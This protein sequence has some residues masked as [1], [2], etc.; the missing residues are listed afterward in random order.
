MEVALQI[1]RAS[2]GVLLPAGD[3]QAADL[4]GSPKS[5]TYLLEV[6][7][8]LVLPVGKKIRFLMTSDDV[9]PLLVVPPLP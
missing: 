4:W 5:D 2:C 9:I 3:Q 8:P 7:K 6:D 1:S